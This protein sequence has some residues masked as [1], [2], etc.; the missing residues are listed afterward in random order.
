M[1]SFDTTAAFLAN[2]T[3][4]VTPT[5]PQNCSICLEIL[6]GPQTST[7]A[8]EHL[9]V[10]I[11]SCGHVYGQKCLKEWIKQQN[12]CPLCRDILYR[13]TTAVLP[14]S[15]PEEQ[16]LLRQERAREAEYGLGLESTM[17]QL[18]QLLVT[19]QNRQR[20]LRKNVDELRLWCRETREDDVESAQQGR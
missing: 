7:S 8:S 4:H 20:E 10:K 15:N 18:G 13:K 2:G 5:E 16:R 1:V 9:A 17:E 3:S 12:T 19:I 6:V 14:V 11:H